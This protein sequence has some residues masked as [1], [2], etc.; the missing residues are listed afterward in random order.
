LVSLVPWAS[1]VPWVSLVPRVLLRC[2][3]LCI[4]TTT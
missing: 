1:L 2:S 4:P 3:I